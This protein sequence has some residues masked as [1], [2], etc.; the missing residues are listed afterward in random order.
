MFEVHGMVVI[1]V[2]CLVATHKFVYR[3]AADAA[4]AKEASAVAP[5]AAAAGSAAAGATPKATSPRQQC[6]L[7][8]IHRLHAYTHI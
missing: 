4:E 7:H 2:R 8:V 5:T 1:C 3:A 6:I